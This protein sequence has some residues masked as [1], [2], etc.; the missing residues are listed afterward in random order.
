[1]E[2]RHGWTRRRIRLRIHP[3]RFDTPDRLARTAHGVDAMEGS[4]AIDGTRRHGSFG[5]GWAWWDLLAGQDRQR[6]IG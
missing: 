1:M 3:R 5:L 2:N 6:S 4:W